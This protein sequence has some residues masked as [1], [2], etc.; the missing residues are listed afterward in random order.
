V[1]AAA[2]FLF[3]KRSVSP[4]QVYGLCKLTWITSSFEEGTAYIRSTKIPALGDIFGRDY[5]T[6]ELAEVADDVVG[7]TGESALRRLVLGETGFTNFYHAYRNSARRWTQ[8]NF[9]AL[10]PLFKTAHKLAS[11]SQGLILTQALE[12]LPGI[13]KANQQ[14]QLMRPEYLLTPAFFSLD[15]RLRFPLINGNEGVKRMLSRLGV[16]KAPLE[17]QYARMI[18]LYGKAGIRDA[19]DLDQA[20]RD[21]PDFIEVGEQKA[22]K[23]LL[24][25]KA[26]EG[27]NL[28]LKD[29]SDVESLQKASTVTNKRLHNKLTNDLRACL[30]NYTLME[31]SSKSALFDVLVKRFDGKKAELLIEVK[32]SSESAHVRMAIGQLLDYWFRI[33]GDS[34]RYLAV[35]LPVEPEAEVKKL[36]AWLD[37]G[38]LWFSG[39]KL[40][41]CS[42]WLKPLTRAQTALAACSDSING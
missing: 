11:D 1:R 14:R 42:A 20:G 6:L 32:S 19:A 24:E 12:R 26:T 16:I 33:N 7:I 8:D 5:A 36:L 21:L 25:R 37:I 34:T 35:L 41:T 28:P 23:K 4:D 27:R 13:P 2:E 30:R 38:L 18:A 15:R 39:D 10:V 29:E 3:S 31:G 17:E 40:E 9:S 22:T